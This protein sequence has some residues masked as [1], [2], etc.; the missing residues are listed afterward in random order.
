MNTNLIKT[1]GKSITKTVSKTVMKA[2]KHSPELLIVAGIISGIGCVITACKSTLKVN[3]ILEESKKTTSLIKETKAAADES[4]T[5][6]EYA[7]D[8]TVNY[9]QTAGKLVCLYGPSLALGALSASSFIASNNIMK[10][11]NLAISAACTAVTKS[12]EDYRGGVVERFGEKVD[13]E[14]R[15]KV[16]TKKIEEVVTDPETGKEKKIKKTVDIAEA[17]GECTF[18]FDRDTSND[19]EEMDDYNDTRIRGVESFC[20]D[21][22]AIRGYLFLNEV[23]AELGF[24]KGTPAGQSL[25]WVRNSDSE[26]S[27]NYIKFRAK[28]VNREWPDGTIAPSILLDF[29]V[30]GNIID[31]F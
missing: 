26:Y 22:L 20:N 16:K 11:R 10:K 2:K 19:W 30:D 5:E 12:F 18:F 24:E 3:D 9:I 6:T 1:M 4:Y 25:G 31:K 7:K 13:Q 23:L 29:N 21:R 15:H 27:D 17:D 28:H 8:L 14:L